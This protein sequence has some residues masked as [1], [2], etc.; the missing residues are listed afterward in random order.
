M[1]RYSLSW[2]LH[3][4]RGG[5]GT[6]MAPRG[7]PQPRSDFPLESGQQPVTGHYTGPPPQLGVDYNQTYH[8]ETG[9]YSAQPIEFPQLP[10]LPTP[11]GSRFPPIEFPPNAGVSLGQHPLRNLFR[12]QLGELRNQRDAGMYT[13]PQFQAQRDVLR[14]NLRSS[15][16]AARVPK[17][18]DALF[19]AIFEYLGQPR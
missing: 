11:P 13:I 19:D 12:A 4:E 1:R 17:R 8:P 16:R 14:G 6:P 2:L 5:G 18:S 10:Q 3:D 9:T 15:V 7:I